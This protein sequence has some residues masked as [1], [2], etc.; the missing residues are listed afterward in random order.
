MGGLQQRACG[1]A[2]VCTLR[3]ACLLSAVA[4]SLVLAATVLPASAQTLDYAQSVA[5]ALKS[6]PT[7][8]ASGAGVDAAQAAVKQARGQL[9]P[10]LSASWT[11]NRS[12]DPLTVFG[13]KL[14]QRKVSFE[15]FGAAQFDPNNLSVEPHNLNHPGAYDNFRTRLRLDIPVFHGG[16]LHARLAQAHALAAAARSGDAAASQQLAYQV[17][18]AYEGVRAARAFVSVTKEAENAAAQYDRSTRQMYNRGVVIK[19]DL[20]TAQVNLQ[21]AKLQVRE[22][23]DQAAT[24]LEHYHLVLGLRLDAPVDVGPP[25]TPPAPTAQRSVLVRQALTDNPGLMALQHRLKADKDG[26]SA[27][28]A[29]YLPRVD[30]SLWEDWNQETPGFDSSSYALMATVS[31]NIFDFGAR[32]GAV[33]RATASRQRTDARLRAARDKLQGRVSRTL[34]SA[35]IAAER[36]NVKILAVQRDKEAQRL[37]SMRYSRGVTTLTDLLAGQSRLDQARADLVSARYQRSVQRAGVWLALGRMD[38][39]DIARWGQ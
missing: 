29:A 8:Q 32:G 2:G 4:T 17:M 38:S 10:H 3:L 21:Q 36:V 33:D 34:R 13:D 22:A 27:A 9:L 5:R 28:R 7:Q 39:R 14:E 19:S 20:L 18:Q 26:V 30:L 35:R 12:D 25:A 6:N 1:A 15:D 31:W 11:V 24:A 37:L 23:V 16:A